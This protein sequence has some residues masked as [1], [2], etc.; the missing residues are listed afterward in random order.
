MRNLLILSFLTAF[1]VHNV[2]FASQCIDKKPDYE[3]VAERPFVFIA[4]VG[5]KEGRRA[6]LIV[7]EQFA[8]LLPDKVV[9][10]QQDDVGA[11]LEDLH[12]TFDTLI[13]LAQ[14]PDVDGNIRIGLCDLVKPVA[15]NRKL[16][17][18]LRAHP[19]KKRK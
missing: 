18:W 1:L 19:R 2:A 9:Y 16:V 15:Y 10:T 6:E 4:T 11:G 13:T 7:K 14:K 5:K 12:T 17:E 3:L 8:G